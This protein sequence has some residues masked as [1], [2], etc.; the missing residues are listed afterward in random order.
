VKTNKNWKHVR[1][2][3]RLDAQTVKRD[4]LICEQ[5][6]ATSRECLLD[7]WKVDFIDSTGM[8]LLIRLQKRARIANHKLV[9]FAPSP[10]VESAIKLMRLEHFF[11]IAHDMP[12][13]HRLMENK[14]ADA[15]VLLQPNY[16]PSKPSIF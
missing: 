15:P 16:F 4:G 13:V 3:E 11:N 7:L 9:L 8:G 10:E 5:A 1:L 14:Q 2:P 6:L 12:M